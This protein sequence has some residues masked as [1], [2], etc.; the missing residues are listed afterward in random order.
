[1]RKICARV[2]TSKCGVYKTN[3]LYGPVSFFLLS[4]NVLGVSHICGNG[5]EFCV[6]V[7]KMTN[8]DTQ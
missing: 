1:M 6:S 7:N 5:P 3:T 4:V 8:R 2:G